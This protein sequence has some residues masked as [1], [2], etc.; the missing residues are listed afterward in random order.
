MR[1]VARGR[2]LAVLFAAEALQT[3]L[4]V[5]GHQILN[6]F[7]HV[8]EHDLIQLVQRQ[9][10]AVIREAVLRKVIRPNPLAAIAGTNQRASLFS[11]F[12]L[13]LLLFHFQQPTSQ[14]PHRFGTVF[15]LAFFVLATDDRIGGQGSDAY[16]AGGLVDF[17]PARTAG[18]ISIDPQFV[19]AD[20]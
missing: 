12:R 2:L 14:N 19:V 8:T 16:G 3:F 7:I 4:A 11:P 9:I 5:E 13:R 1:R 20:L 17:L 6:Q 15:M 18:K 10:D